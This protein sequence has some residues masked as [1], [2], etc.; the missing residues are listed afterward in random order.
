MVDLTKDP[1]AVADSAWRK[2][3]KDFERGPRVE[4]NGSPYGR[5]VGHHGVRALT[6]L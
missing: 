6:R 3:R 5:G 2:L 4:L 1:I